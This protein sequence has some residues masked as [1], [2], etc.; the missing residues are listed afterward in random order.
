MI[1]RL[2]RLKSIIYICV[3]FLGIIF[4]GF[5]Q[6]IELQIHPVDLKT[7][8]V[9]F[10]NSFLN[11][12]FEVR[13][14][15][16]EYVNTLYE[17]GYLSA[18]LDSLT[19]DSIRKTAHIYYGPKYQWAQLNTDSIDEELL[20]RTGFRNKQ[21]LN[22]PFSVKQVSNFFKDALEYLENT[23][24][25]FAEIKLADVVIN[26]TNI[27]ATVKLEKN[28]Y[29]S[30]DS[31]EILGEDTRLSKSYIESI[32]GIRSKQSYNENLIKKIGSRIE[33]NPFMNQLKPYE[34]I[35]TENSC[36]LVLILKPQKSNLFDGVIGVQPQENNERVVF[37]GDIKFSIGNIVGQGER[38]N[39]RWQRLADQTQQIDAA[40]K[41]PFLFKTP[42]GFGYDLNIFRRDTTFNNVHHKIELPYRLSNGT[43][44]FGY[45]DNFRTS[46][47]SVYDYENSTEIPPFNDAENRV[48]G[49]GFKGDF[50]FNK[51]NPYQGWLIAING[52]AGK[53]KIIQNP[54][55]ELVNYDSVELE[56]NLLQGEVSV[57]FFQPVSKQST[58][59]IRGRSAFKQT[60]N[61]VNNQAYRIGGLLT[62]R[63]FDEQSIFASSYAIGTIEYRLLFDKNSRISV[64]YDMAWYELKSI[65]HFTTDTPYSFGAGITFGTKSG[66]FSLTYALGSQFNNP[67]NFRTGKIHFGFINVF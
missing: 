56:S 36:K 58:F 37:T 24:Y 59:L 16:K 64:F 9:P 65:T 50:V 7:A 42:I 5:S 13:I 34:V 10:E 2:N 67:I 41:V 22:K 39:L 15:L 45:F 27:N 48:Y 31:I 60:E 4:N 53:N 44:F 1:G 23:G 43:E 63:G 21:F 28:R 61:L 20:S 32:I 40:F 38:L 55:L 35:F 57:S 29:Y 8:P 18:S 54:S 66:M 47:I 14:A 46:L 17:K 30:I 6:K 52:G 3:F 26:E 12:E 19:G 33:E 25:P 62:L 49:I 11:S 51:F